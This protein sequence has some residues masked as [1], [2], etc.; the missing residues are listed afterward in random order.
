MISA[1][2]R[3]TR[4]TFFLCLLLPIVTLVCS[5]ALLGATMTTAFL[6]KTSAVTVAAVV[7]A[8]VID[9]LLRRMEPAID[10][11]SAEAGKSL[12]G[13]PNRWL[14]VAVAA[15]AAGSLALELAVIRWQGTVWEIFAFYKNFGLLSCFAGLGLGYALARK[16]RVPIVMSLPLFA[17]Q[18]ILLI[19]LR[20]G[21]GPE[22]TASLLAAPIKEQLNMGF[23]ASTS[24]PHL[25][26]VY[27]F[28]G[29]VMLLTAL[30][31][32]P[33]GQV[34]GRLLERMTQLR[35]YGLNLLG[36]I[37]GV[38]LVLAL[39]LLWTPP[40][41]WFIPCFAVYVLLQAHSRRALAIG[42][43]ASLAAVAVLDWPVSFG[44][45]RIY[46]PY[47]LLER[48]SGEHGL[49]M[50]VAAGTYYQRI[51]DLSA[52][53][54]A[55]DAD[56]RP[57]A[58]Y[59]ELPFRLRPRPEH[60]AIMGAGTGNDVAA[61]LRMGAAHVDAI[62]IDPAILQLGAAYHPEQP[63]DDARVTC[64]VND[65]RNFIRGT[66]NRYDLIVYGLLDSHT[67]LSQASSVRL[68]S[69]VYTVEGLRDARNRLEDDGVLSLSFCVLSPDI[70]RK[71][72]LMMQKAFDGAPPI[73]ILAKYD[74]AVIFAQSKHGNLQ[75]NA[76]VLRGTDFVDQSDLYAKADV[77]ADVSTDDWPFFYMP[78]RVYPLSYI[79]MILL[80]PLL[81]V[82]LFGNFI[83]ERPRFSHAAYFFMGAGFML[84]ETKGITELGL[85]FG[86][87]WQVIGI[88]IVAILAM[89]YLANLAVMKLGLR[90]PTIPFILLLLSLGLGLAMAKAGGFPATRSGQAASVIVLTCPMFFSGIA[91]SS[92]LARTGDISAVLALN[93]FG[94][95]CGGLLEY[96]SMYFGFQFLYWVAMGLYLGA[97]LTD[98]L[99]RRTT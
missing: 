2:L 54:V 72:F 69:F 83:R 40:V 71:I 68:D 90:R 4:L 81:S 62:E 58:R 15:S 24:L 41:I 13:L 37:A 23:A 52:K 12:D 9:R 84:I 78:R 30:V 7:C 93:L 63:Y 31:F 44:V 57:I 85:M 47:Q 38:V 35:A 42:L 16:D 66:T 82:F 39:S 46:S 1:Y 20:N 96:N 97:L 11:L 22:R 6:A 73:C 59:Y 45:E 3:L 51:H 60:V 29:V 74:C 99:V 91:F 28:L 53:S 17:V 14:P 10:Q 76:D 26:A 94:A 8:I 18:A 34:C 33:M 64:V 49:S 5:R 92:L 75:L 88:V 21:M 19:G 87:T 67:L 48:G 36:S 95:M 43:L 25:I 86:N 55:A 77:R 98:M 61:A 56:R 65:A 80:V 79:P 50:I 89:A 32:L 70:G 27:S